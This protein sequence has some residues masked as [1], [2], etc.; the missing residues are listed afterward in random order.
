LI[1]GAGVSGAPI[2]HGADVVESQAVW[3]APPT[4]SED[5]EIVTLVAA[6]ATREEAQQAL[7]AFGDDLNPRIEEVIGDAW[8]DAWKAHFAAF[9]LSPRIVIEPPW[10][11]ADRALIEEVAG[12]KVLTL[13]P[14]RAFGTGLHPTTALVAT[15]VDALGDTLVDLSV[16]DLGCGSGILSLV[17]L[18]LGAKHV[19]ATDLDLDAVRITRENAAHLGLGDRIEV[20]DSPFERIG[21]RFPLVLANI[22]AEVLVPAAAAITATVE[23]GG[24]LVLSG[25][26]TTQRDRV[27]NAYPE[28]AL[29]DSPIRGE[30]VALVLQKPKTS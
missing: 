27:R 6:F 16:L 7:E 14:S 23:E 10:K 21:R 24:T 11:P 28:L 1:R 3:D 22:Q 12:T 15:I 4:D 17:A 25:I 20:D 5:D 19:R 30:W 2:D 9:R 26:L 13:E 29:I 18:L 8:R